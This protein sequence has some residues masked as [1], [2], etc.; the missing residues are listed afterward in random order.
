MLSLWRLY[1]A[2]QTEA[3]P[4]PGNWPVVAQVNTAADL[5]VVERAQ[6]F[7]AAVRA[8]PGAPAPRRSIA[9]PGLTH[10]GATVA[11]ALAAVLATAPPRDAVEV[12]LDDAG[13]L[14]LAEDVVAGSDEPPGAVALVDGY[15]VRSGDAGS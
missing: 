15:A 3:L 2:V 12:G 10:H 7:Q 11:Q 4:V 8:D 1:E 5:A 13:G 9:D 14:I 6:T